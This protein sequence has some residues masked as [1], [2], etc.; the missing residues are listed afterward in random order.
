MKILVTAGS[1]WVK[2]DEIRILTNKFRGVTGLKIARGLQKKGHVVK[3]LINPHCTGKITG[4]PVKYFRYFDEFKN[5]VTSM[6]KKDKFDAIIHSAAVSDYILLRTLPGKVSSGKP[7]LT[8][9]LWPAEKIIKR[10]KSLARGSL[11]IQFKLEIEREGLIEKAYRSLIAN[12]SDAVVANALDDLK[13]G[14][15]CFLID[16]GR[17]VKEVKSRTVLI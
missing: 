6:L 16:R 8:L 2:I 10:I 3:L 17:K 13:K 4:I 5:A 14:Y 15:S 1:T 7:D 9:R 12:G 11:V